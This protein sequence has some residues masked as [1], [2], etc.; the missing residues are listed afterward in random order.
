MLRAPCASA[1]VSE[2]LESIAKADAACV[3]SHLQ[4]SLEATAG[5]GSARDAIEFDGVRSTA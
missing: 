4:R 2:T 3:D 5:D 1:R